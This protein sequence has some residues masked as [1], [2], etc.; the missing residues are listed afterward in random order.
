MT[1][2]RQIL[3]LLLSASATPLNAIAQTAGKVHRIG[4]LG[5]RVRSTPSNP[6]PY[7]DAFVDGMRKLG[8]VEGVNLTVEWR[9]AEG[10]SDRLASL[11][12]ELVQMKVDL[13]VTHSAP[14]SQALKRAT[15]SIPIVVAATGDP[16]GSGLVTSLARPGGNLTGLSLM[17]TD[18]ASK[19]VELLKTLKPRLARIA[20]LTNPDN[21]SH[22]VLLKPVQNA[23]QQIGIT[24]LLVAARLQELERAFAGMA[25]ERVEAVAILSDSLFIGQRRQIAELLA[26]HRL[27]SVYENRLEVEA[28]GLMSYGADAAI[29][30][31]RAATYVDKIFKGAKPGELPF[32]Q[33]LVLQLVINR[34]T[35]TALGLKIPQELLLRADEVIE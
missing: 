29:L 18:F 19:Q 24:T 1:T 8:Y 15:D 4:F 25:R 33:P 23:A 13:I 9:F 14:A 10:K 5:M 12:A 27:A 31:R 28:G 35:A 26:K 11:A 3:T 30:Y 16:V 2:R 21:P 7:Y 6:D 32:E 22:P 17:N 34:K 20:I